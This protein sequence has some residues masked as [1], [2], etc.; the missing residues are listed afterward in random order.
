MKHRVV[1]SAMDVTVAVPLSMQNGANG[2]NLVILKGH[3]FCLGPKGGKSRLIKNVVHTADGREYG[4]L[5]V[6]LMSDK[7]LSASERLPIRPVKS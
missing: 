5:I 4:P 3:L 1:A 2:Y 7:I 6:A